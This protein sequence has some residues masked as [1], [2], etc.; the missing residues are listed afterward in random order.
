MIKAPS[1]SEPR[2]VAADTAGRAGHF[3]VSDSEARQA[4]ERQRNQT[5]GFLVGGI[6]HEINNPVQSIMNF[7][8]LIKSRRGSPQISDY[9]DE[10][11]HESQRVA[12]IV[13]NLISFAR[14]DD[15]GPPVEADIGEAIQR[16]VSLVRAVM[17]K[18]RVELDVQIAEDLPA[19]ECRVAQVQQVV[20]NLLTGAREALNGRPAAQADTEQA[21]VRV[22]VT[23]IERQG[24]RWVRI[25][26]E[27]N[28]APISPDDLPELF[29]GSRSIRGRDQGT[30]LGLAIGRDIA[31]EHGGSLDVE[32]DAGL[33]RFNLDLPTL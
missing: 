9:A 20:M 1:E 4:R 30:N 11:L 5:V 29:S 33:T 19:V 23:A 7:A 28:G 15:A 24:A 2:A 18:E 21:R 10:I 25:S 6:A 32:S 22:A 16:V 13:R 14:A 31:L 26:V 12:T 17:R 27:D 8:Q 3:G